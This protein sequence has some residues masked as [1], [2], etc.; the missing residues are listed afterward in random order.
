VQTAIITSC[1][2]ERYSKAWSIHFQAVRESGTIGTFSIIF[3]DRPL[4][5][6]SPEDPAE[7]FVSGAG[8]VLLPCPEQI[9]LSCFGIGS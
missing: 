3:D 2:L 1:S 9:K 4:P 6:K 8:V 7:I 5:W